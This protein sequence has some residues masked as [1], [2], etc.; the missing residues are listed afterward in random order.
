MPINRPA[1]KQCRFA[2]RRRP[3]FSVPLQAGRA[4]LT[5]AA[6]ESRLQALP[7]AIPQPVIN[8]KEK[9]MMPDKQNPVATVRIYPVSASIWRNFSDKQ[10]P[11]YSITLQ[12][13]YK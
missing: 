2:V 10:E 8:V 11:F 3:C 5:A 7:E 12:R 13:T 9:A 6:P 4:R 1:K